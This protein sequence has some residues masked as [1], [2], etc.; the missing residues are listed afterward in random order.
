[1]NLKDKRLSWI[2]ISWVWSRKIGSPMIELL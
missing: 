2:N 1:M